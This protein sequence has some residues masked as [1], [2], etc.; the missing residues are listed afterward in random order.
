M[1]STETVQVKE[2]Y[3][4]KLV[5]IV[6]DDVAGSVHRASKQSSKQSATSTQPS[7]LYTFEV[8]SVSFTSGIMTDAHSEAIAGIVGVV[9]CTDDVAR[10][11]LKV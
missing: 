9:G 5:F 6:A 11:W 10:R 4:V 1:A 8:R 2:W 3:S 7:F